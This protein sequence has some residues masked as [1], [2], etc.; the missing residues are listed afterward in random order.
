MSLIA[1]EGME[2]YAYHGY[3]P[4]EQIIGGQYT[5][6]V[7]LST[8][9]DL[10]ATKD[11]LSGTINYETVFTIARNVM[12]KPSKLIE[13]LAQQILIQIVDLKV[14]LEHVKVRVSK[15]HPP[16]ASRVER[17]YVEVEHFFGV[18]R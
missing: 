16:F 4:E 5:V 10:A 17:T 6:D 7:Y 13:Y 11:K 15:W 3:Y 8:K 2:F 14:D 12:E 9:F 1:L 18:E